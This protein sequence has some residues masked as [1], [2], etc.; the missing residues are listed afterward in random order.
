MRANPPAA[1]NINP[2]QL[3]VIGREQQL[4]TVDRK[5]GRI[6]AKPANDLDGRSDALARRRIPKNPIAITIAGK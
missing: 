6:D 3:F 1:A 5:I 4:A 2:R